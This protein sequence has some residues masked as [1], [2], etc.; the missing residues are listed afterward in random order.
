MNR[1][2]THSLET[3]WRDITV[4]WR[5]IIVCFFSLLA[6]AGLNHTRF[7]ICDRCFKQIWK[8]GK[9]VKGGKVGKVGKVGKAGKVGMVVREGRQ[10]RQGR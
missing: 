1:A 3:L 6:K 8:V 10:G 2:R 5:T 4:F 9:V 7:E